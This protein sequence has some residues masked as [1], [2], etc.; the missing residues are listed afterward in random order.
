MVANF[1]YSILKY[2]FLKE[3]VCYLIQNS[4]VFSLGSNEQHVSIGSGDDLASNKPL[5]LLL[6][7]TMY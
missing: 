2:L 6:F 5:P 3:L 7:A 4:L 1:A